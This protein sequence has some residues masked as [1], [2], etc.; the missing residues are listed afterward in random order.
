MSRGGSRAAS[1]ASKLARSESIRTW[2]REILA[3]Y[4]HCRF[5]PGEPRGVYPSATCPEHG[6][7]REQ[8]QAR[9]KARRILA[10]ESAASGNGLDIDAD[11][12]AE[13][14]TET[15]A[16]EDDTPENDG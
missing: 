4:C 9:D 12:V 10:R 8:A 13:P 14:K 3:G 2:A 15:V 16:V 6:F 1:E 7:R 5:V 11:H